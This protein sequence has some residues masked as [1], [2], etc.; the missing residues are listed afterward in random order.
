MRVCSPGQALRRLFGVALL[1]LIGLQPAVAEDMWEGVFTY[2]Q[3]MAD[4]GNPEAQVKLGEMYEEGHGTARDYEMARKW[5]QKAADQGYE[6]AKK[7]LVQLGARKQKEAEAKK[8]AEQD[9]QACIK[10]IDRT[11]ECNCPLSLVPAAIKITTHTV[12]AVRTCQGDL[13][14]AA[15]SRSG[16]SC[17]R[18][19]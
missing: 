10:G 9:A 14:K 17:C 7:K 15:S 5:Y 16:F 3:K 18:T 12:T 8:R 6:P 11:P 19:H 13:G 4:Y 2:Q 1:S